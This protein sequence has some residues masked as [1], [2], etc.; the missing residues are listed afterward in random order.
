M[1]AGSPSNRISKLQ[2][3]SFH[4]S[5]AHP[6]LKVDYFNSINSKEKAYWLGF[7]HADGCI[8]RNQHGSIQVRFEL[9]RDSE[10]VIDRFCLCL[11]LDKNK[12]EYRL[13]NRGEKRFV[14]IRFACKETSSAL[15]E[16]GLMFQKSKIVE[17]PMLPDESLEL[18]FLLGY[19]DG[20]GQQGTTRISS[21]SIRFFGTD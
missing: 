16:H 4:S 3:K 11:G 10:D 19:Y 17:Y 7:L 5:K 2:F 6:N 1:I 13:N 20:D 8:T 18:A 9:S 21:G 12:K 15:V 14:E